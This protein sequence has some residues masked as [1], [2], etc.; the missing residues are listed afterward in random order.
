MNDFFQTPDFHNQLQTAAHV[1]LACGE[2][3]AL[4]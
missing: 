4:A 2:Q 1:C 3:T